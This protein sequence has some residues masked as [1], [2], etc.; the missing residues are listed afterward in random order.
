[1]CLYLYLSVYLITGI[2]DQVR[3]N[4]TL[5]RDIRYYIMEH[6]FPITCAVFLSFM[7][8]WISHESTPARVA[9]PVTTFLTL[10]TMLDH[11]RASANISGTADVLEIF[12]NVSI[13]FV[14]G[15]MFEFGVITTVA[16]QWE[17]VEIN[18]I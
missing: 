12:L 4:F 7:S 14:F 2:F 16:M 11:V 8:F 5:K 9:L 17:K 1:M 15:V 3:I 6:Y 10:T 13:F 18:M